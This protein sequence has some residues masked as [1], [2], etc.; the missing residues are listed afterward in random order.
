M[1]GL[2][3]VSRLACCVSTLLAAPARSPE[4]SP[5]PPEAVANDHRTPA[6]TLRDGVLTLAIVAQTVQWRMLAADGPAVQVETFAEE[7]RTP[8]VPGP[9]VRVPIG[10]RV[11]LTIRNTL[12]DTLSFRWRCVSPCSKAQ[13]LRVAPGEVQ[14]FSAPLDSAGT[15]VYR[16]GIYAGGRRLGGGRGGQLGGVIVVDPTGART[17]RILVVSD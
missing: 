4:S 7:G 17:D 8:T 13:D 14:R 10:T 15:F 9:L 12:R 5:S 11:E 3:A 1:I 6:G 16:G 2:L